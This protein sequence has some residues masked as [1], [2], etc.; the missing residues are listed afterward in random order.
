MSA[1]LGRR[2][3]LITATAGGLAV[4]AGDA[5]AVRAT[6]WR[7]QGGAL[8]ADSTI[9]LS[10]PERAA[11]VEA[12]TA[13]REEIARLERIFSLYRTDSALSLLNRQGQ[14]VNPP[15]ELVELL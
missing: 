8:G 15:L 9:L 5:R 12:I 3:L 1:R 14:L 7:W 6:T 13:C 2:R 4:M 10:H 11:A